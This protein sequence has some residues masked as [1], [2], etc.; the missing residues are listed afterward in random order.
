MTRWIDADRAVDRSRLPTALDCSPGQHSTKLTVCFLF[1]GSIWT[2]NLQAFMVFLV[3]IS[4]AHSIPSYANASYTK[5]LQS[6]RSFDRFTCPLSSRTCQKSWP[7]MNR[8]NISLDY[9]ALVGTNS[10]RLTSCTGGRS[11]MKRQTLMCLS[12]EALDDAAT[13]AG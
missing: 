8:K 9:R 1:F 3:E 6:V 11:V 4:V 2:K 12:A 5:R 10:V 13:A 7:G